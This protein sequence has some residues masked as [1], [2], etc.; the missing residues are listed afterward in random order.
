MARS[1]GQRP[2][3]AILL[4]VTLLLACTGCAAYLTTASTAESFKR[5]VEDP[6]VS[7]LFLEDHLLG[8]PPILLPFKITGPRRLSI[9]VRSACATRSR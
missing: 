6:E 5:A 7:V 2:L 1:R 8:I 4:L 3:H 9:V